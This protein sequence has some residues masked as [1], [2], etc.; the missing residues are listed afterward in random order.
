MFQCTVL[1]DTDERQAPH[2]SGV[3]TG[4]T[5]RE[6]TKFVSTEHR[7]A[8]NNGLGMWVKTP[9]GWTCA[10]Y[11]RPDNTVKVYVRVQEIDPEP[12]LPTPEVLPLTV[13]IETE[14]HHPQTVTLHPK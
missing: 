12:P 8:D 10:S 5:L 11:P 2:I 1:I 13:T 7:A 9:G 4:V 14:Y 6:G 3:K